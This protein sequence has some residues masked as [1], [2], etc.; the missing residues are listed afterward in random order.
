MPWLM[1]RVAAVADAMEALRFTSSNCIWNRDSN[2]F[3][4]FSRKVQL[5]VLKQD[6]VAWQ[7]QPNHKTTEVLCYNPVSLDHTLCA[8]STVE[9]IMQQKAGLLSQSLQ[10]LCRRIPQE[11]KWLLINVMRC[12]FLWT[13]ADGSAV[14]DVWE[15]S[16]T[17]IFL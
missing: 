2:A 17:D 3:L 8:G 1:T 11:F 16:K 13:I 12:M 9:E 7:M 5:V 6:L 15:T 4:Y 14:H 10:L